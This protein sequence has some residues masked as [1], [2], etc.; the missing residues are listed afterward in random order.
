[1]TDNLKDKIIN[2]LNSEYSDIPTFVYHSHPEDIFYLRG[3]KILFNYNTINHSLRVE[4][5]V[6]KMLENCMGL[7]YNEVSELFMDWFSDKH[8][9][10]ITQCYRIK[11]SSL[12]PFIELCYTNHLVGYDY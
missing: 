6:W 2:Y 10:N 3:L 9:L 12:W 4:D 11:K 8:N 1:M 5:C 7:E